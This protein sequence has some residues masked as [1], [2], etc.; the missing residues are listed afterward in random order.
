MQ[1]GQRRVNHYYFW[2][3][4]MT[5]H[6]SCACIVALVLYAQRRQET[7]LSSVDAPS[8]AAAA[9]NSSFLWSENWS[10]RRTLHCT[11]VGCQQ[12]KEEEK[13]GD[14]IVRHSRQMQ[15]EHTAQ[16]TV[17][18]HHQSSA[19]ESACALSR[20]KQTIAHNKNGQLQ[21]QQQWWWWWWNAG[22]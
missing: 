16:Y 18:I 20:E 6:L 2:Q 5:K 22:E 8:A 21:Q 19:S 3:P 13:S 10:A 7:P 1:K 4:I 14:L 11:L 17:H 15:P 12:R 9:G